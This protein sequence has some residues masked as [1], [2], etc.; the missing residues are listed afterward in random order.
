MAV[1][2]A[3][4]RF[5][6]SSPQTDVTQVH[7]YD[8]W[9]ITY[10]NVTSLRENEEREDDTPSKTK[11]L[12]GVFDRFAQY[13]T[14]IL[15]LIFLIA[16]TAIIGLSICLSQLSHNK[17]ETAARL[18]QLRGR[19][20]DL[21]SSLIN[22]ILMK[23]AAAQLLEK[24]LSQTRAE[25]EQTKKSLDKIQEQWRT[26]NQQLQKTIQEKEDSESSSKRLQDNLRSTENK[27]QVKQ[28]ELTRCESNLGR[29]NS[30]SR[31]SAQALN[32]VRTYLSNTQNKLRTTENNLRSKV[33]E[34]SDTKRDLQKVSRDL[35]ESRELEEQQRKNLTDHIQRLSDAEQCI[36]TSCHSDKNMHGMNYNG[37]AYCTSGW[38]QIDDNCYYFSNEKTARIY[39]EGDC[40]RR[41][42]TLAKIDEDD[43]IMREFINRSQKSYWIGLQ[44]VDKTW[45][46]PDKTNKTDFEPTGTV[47]CVMA[48]PEL[49]TQW[50][51]FQIPW[52]CQKKTE[53]CNF[54]M[55]TLQCLGE[56]IGFFGR[57]LPREDV[58]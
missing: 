48:T 15:S 24:V 56:K 14:I 36:H 34:L 1:V 50:C 11:G 22:N 4:L 49:K 18:E 33:T 30:Q 52:I 16:L 12:R 39:A 32:Q 10:E 37:F 38:Q 31:E 47:P 29:I 19:H 17:Q 54:N 28:N 6:R 20:E 40:Q 23:D 44:K 25:L 51:N 9:D 42:A 35:S 46:W 43:S 45:Q 2:Y 55:D 21:N 53:R 8:D 41:G 7:S 5:V 27:L 58:M 57:K 13:I 26:T 3:D